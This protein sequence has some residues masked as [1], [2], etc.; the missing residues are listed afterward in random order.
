MKCAFFA[1]LS[2]IVF[3][4]DQEILASLLILH[5]SVQK[6]LEIESNFEGEMTGYEYT[7]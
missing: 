3:T 4:T 5:T 1:V 6:D 2:R 7:I